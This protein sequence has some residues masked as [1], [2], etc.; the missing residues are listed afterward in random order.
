MVYNKKKSKKNFINNSQCEIS[1]NIQKVII[2]SY[3]SALTSMFGFSKRSSTMV[4]RPSDEAR[5]NGVQLQ[6]IKRKFHKVLC[7]WN[8]INTCKSKNIIKKVMA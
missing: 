5:Y 8:L 2:G 7:E 1:L 4:T 3:V 6:N